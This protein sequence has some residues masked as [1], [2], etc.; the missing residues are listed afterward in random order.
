VLGE[1]QIWECF[2]SA[3]RGDGQPAVTPRSVLPTMALL[4]AA[5]QSSR[6]GRAVDL[7]DVRWGDD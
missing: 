2:A 5:H 7:P 1:T 6:T 3:I 4:D